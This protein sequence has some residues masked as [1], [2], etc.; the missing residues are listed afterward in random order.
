MSLAVP[1]QP[2]SSLPEYGNSTGAA[3]QQQIQLRDGGKPSILRSSNSMHQLQPPVKGKVNHLSKHFYKS[4]HTLLPAGNSRGIGTSGSSMTAT[5]AA[6]TDQTASMT[7][8]LMC[9]TA[10]TPRSERHQQE[11]K[12]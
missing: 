11:K 9:T 5:A 4:L 8:S 2:F 6:N 7:G 3:E 10:T 12:K 1:P